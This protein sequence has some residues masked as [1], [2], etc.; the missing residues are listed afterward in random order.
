VGSAMVELELELKLR[1]G[2]KVESWG[3][4][5]LEMKS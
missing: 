1:V 4:G 5:E 2:A 3:A